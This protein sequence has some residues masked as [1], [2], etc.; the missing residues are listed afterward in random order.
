[1]GD[2]F[3]LYLYI[4]HLLHS[5]AHVHS[6]IHIFTQ[7]GGKSKPFCLYLILLLL[8]FCGILQPCLVIPHFFYL[9]CMPLV[10]FFLATDQVFFSFP[11]CSI[12]PSSVKIWPSLLSLCLPL[13]LLIFSHSALLLQLLLHILSVTFFSCFA[14]SSLIRT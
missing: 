10:N 7:Y 1:M 8:R 3:L 11:P 2:F 5:S 6:H 9:V 12:F 4:F 13:S 14:I